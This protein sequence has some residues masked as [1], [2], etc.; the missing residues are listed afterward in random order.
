MEDENFNFRG[1]M[2]C[3]R[4]GEQLTY[5]KERPFISRVDPKEPIGLNPVSK[6]MVAFR[7]KSFTELIKE[8]MKH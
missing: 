5:V 7:K 8:E 4:P 1:V 3:N 2:M 6:T